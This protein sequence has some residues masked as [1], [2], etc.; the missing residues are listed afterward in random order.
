MQVSISFAEARVK[1]RP[2]PFPLNDGVR[3]EVFTRRGGLYFGIAHLLDYPVS[4]DSMLYRFAD[5]NAG[6]Y[7]SRNAAFQQAVSSLS[8]MRL[9][10]DGDLLREG[11]SEPSQTELAVRKLAIGLGERQIRRDLE[12]GTVHEFEETD[13][14]RKLFELADARGPAPRALVPSIRLQSV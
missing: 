2:Y 10:I 8:G 11:S 5:F 7:A 3:S 1:E 13:L 12:Q 4:Y 9:A 14:Y 6:H